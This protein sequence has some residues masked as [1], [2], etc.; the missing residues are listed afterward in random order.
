MEE[1]AQV[2]E[3]ISR[4]SDQLRKHQKQYYVDA[5]PTISDQE[6]DRMLDRLLELE[7]QYPSLITAD[8]PSQRV[9]S[10]LGSSFPEVSHTVPVLS[11][12]K[13]YSTESLMQWIQRIRNRGSSHLSCILEEKMDGVSLVLYYEQGLLTRAVTR[14]NGFIGNDVTQNAK[15][16]SSIPLRL[17]RPVTIA[18]RGEVFLLKSDFEQL[19]QN[20][21]VPYA[22]PRNLA[23]GTLRR[24]KSSE[25]AKVPLRMYVYEAY[26]EAVDGQIHTHVE[27]LSLLFD[28]G[29]S[30]NPR[31]SMFTDDVSRIKQ[32]IQRLS[33]RPMQIEA[34]DGIAQYIE[35]VN[36]ERERLPYEI[37]GLVLKVDELEMREFL[38][39]TGHH[40]RWALAY[41][42][43][44]PEAQTVVKAIDVQVGRTGRVTPVARVEK[45][46]V[47]NSMV[48][49]VTLH[50]QDYIEMLELA[51]GDTVAISK[52]G[53]VIPAIERVVEKNEEGATTWIMPDRCPSCNTMLIRDGAHQFCPNSDCPDQV[54][55][56]ISFFVGREQMDIDGMGPET[57]AYLYR[58]GL[59]HDIPDIY[60]ID[61][62]NLIGEPGFGERKVQSLDQAVQASRQRPF[63]TVLVSLGI[64]DFGKKAVD[65]LLASGITRMQQLLEMVDT[66]KTEP[67]L[68]IKGFG[69][70]TVNALFTWLSD[71]RM[72]S[73]IAALAEIGLQMA[74]HD[75]Q[76]AT[77]L[78]QQFSGQ[79]WCVT[80]SFTRFS[81]R[82]LALQEIEARGG[83]TV[84]SVTGKTTHL[85]AGTGAGSKLQQA[86]KLGVTIVSEEDFLSM[87]G[88]KVRWIIE[89]KN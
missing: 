86:A 50:N 87:L 20:L 33:C 27:A 37:D 34:Y 1:L 5:R 53:D 18:V 12:D 73:R 26:G 16:I 41:K 2:K 67:L 17:T 44:A 6:Y 14:G 22:N 10:D 61:Y 36:R 45:V 77:Q 38:G 64:P 62:R 74:Q 43:D 4:L 68:Q 15:T 42:F 32:T 76:Q 58:K 25:T 54:L 60:R 59:L 39:Y 69:E 48:S 3:E 75:E 29:F 52:R 81:P 79:V 46:K 57:V 80:G 65:L 55:G 49:N 28:L 30:I 83:R 82:T 63:R 8:S 89:Q 88:G 24:L 85:L 11:L 23:A 40:P 56:R 66:H 71:T 35:Q 78:P 47:G 7:Q 31:F 21:D 51:I 84:S 72:R 70:K 13:A 19:N 9:G